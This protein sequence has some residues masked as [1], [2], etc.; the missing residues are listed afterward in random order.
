MDNLIEKAAQ[1]IG[2]II[3]QPIDPNLPVPPVLN[4]VFD[5]DTAEPGEEIKIYTVED[6]NQGDTITAVGSDGR[7][8]NYKIDPQ[9]PAVIPFT[10]VQSRLERVH[11]D[12]ILNSPDQSVIA[13]RKAAITR[14]LDKKVTKEALDLMLAV[15]SQEVLQASGEDVYSLILKMKHKVEDYGDNFILLVG[16]DVS[17]AIESYERDNATNFHY[18]ISVEDMLAKK[19]IKMVKVYETAVFNFIDTTATGDPEATNV[20]VLAA[21]KLILVARD[22]RIAKGKPGVY[23]RRKIAP[24]IAQMMGSDVDAT[25]RASTVIPL[26]VNLDG[27]NT[28][29]FGIHAFEQRVCAL[30]NYRGIAWSTLA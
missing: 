16:T 23:I 26:P 2:K 22:S 19:G 7:I 24:A 30:L 20:K 15:G 13:R 25:Y 27:T 29:A 10:S 14:A 18:V 21:D 5:Y 12:A 1:D 4:E 11:V 8:V 17:N 3:G 9:T 28:L 6:T